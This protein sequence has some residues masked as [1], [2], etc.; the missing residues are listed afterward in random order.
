M[1]PIVELVLEVW[2]AVAVV[3]LIAHSVWEWRK[4]RATDRFIKETD[5]SI[6]EAEARIRDGFH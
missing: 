3:G 6:K 1:K 2:I 4:I 5:K